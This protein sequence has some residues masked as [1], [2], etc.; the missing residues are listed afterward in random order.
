MSDLARALLDELAGDPVA[1]DRVRELVQVQDPGFTA[2]EL[3]TV[4][5][6]TVSTLA[7]E[8]DARNARSGRRSLAVSLRPSS[9]GAVT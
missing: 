6:Y 1:L 7:A 9:A 5:A 4:T 8:L 2:N 3:L